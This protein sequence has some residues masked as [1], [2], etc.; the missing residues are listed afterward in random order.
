MLELKRRMDVKKHSTRECTDAA[1][2][3]CSGESSTFAF[4]KQAL[5]ICITGAS[6]RRRTDDSSDES[7]VQSKS[8]DH[9]SILRKSLPSRTTSEFV[10]DVPDEFFNMSKSTLDLYESYNKGE[11]KSDPEGSKIC[12]TA[13]TDSTL[14]KTSWLLC[15]WC[16]V[17]RVRRFDQEDEQE[18]L[19]GRSLGSTLGSKQDVIFLCSEACWGDFI[20][21]HSDIP[22]AKEAPWGSSVP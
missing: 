21:K 9:P 7:S 8:W 10:E 12:I 3:S 16:R 19:R 17:K 18:R 22:P 20:D 1:R 11:Y 4:I 5:P 14:P 13:A 15:S 6:R 2:E